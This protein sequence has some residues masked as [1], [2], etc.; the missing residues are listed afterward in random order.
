MTDTQALRDLLVKVEAGAIRHSDLDAFIPVF[1]LTTIGNDAHSA[2]N[3][4]LD[5]AKALHEAVLPGWEWLIGK[6]NAKIFPFNDT[7]DV[8]GC[9]GMADTAAR[10]WL[11]CIL[12]A[13][14]AQAPP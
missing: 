5:A 11:I 7:H 13:L 3:G 12:R 1:G 6:S 9:Y 14:I 4:S 8:A 2:Y 10:A